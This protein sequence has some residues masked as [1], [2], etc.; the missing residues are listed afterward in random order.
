MSNEDLKRT[1]AKLAEEGKKPQLCDQELWY[2]PLTEKSD[3][4]G[5]MAGEPIQ[6]Y[7]MVP[8]EVWPLHATFS[9]TMSDNSMIGK[10]IGRGDILVTRACDEALDGDVV[11]AIVDGESV[12]RGYVEDENGD[13]WLMPRNDEYEPIRWK[14]HE[15]VRLSGRVIWVIKGAPRIKYAD[16]KADIAR[17]KK[18]KPVV[19][20]VS[21][22]NAQRVIKKLGPDVEVMRDWF[23]FYR[24]LVQYRVI[25]D[26]DYKGFCKLIKETL[27]DHKPQPKYDEMQRIDNGCFRRPVAEWTL[28]GSDLKRSSRFDQYKDL[29]MAVTA[30]LDPLAV[31]EFLTKL[32]E[33]PE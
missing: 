19:K 20:I 16:C 31:P 13:V 29:G 33:L 22:E 28:E 7:M 21:R 12:V 17:A 9:F 6:Q 8:P 24:P 18:G 1:F 5:L 26:K 14:D 10:G 32:P 23:S 3:T 11:L 4:G 27:P 2:E 15:D 25:T 30:L